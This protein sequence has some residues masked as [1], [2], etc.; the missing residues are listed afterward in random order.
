MTVNEIAN[1]VKKVI[2]Q[3]VEIE[4]EILMTIGLII[5]HQKN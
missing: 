5:Y 4:K 3:D 2:G 1:T